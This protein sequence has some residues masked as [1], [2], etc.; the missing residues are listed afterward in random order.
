MNTEEFDN[1][2]KILEPYKLKTIPRTSSNHYHDEK[3]DV[4]HK[5]RETTAEHVFSTLRLADYFLETEPEF[6]GLDKL[7]VYELLMYHD[8]VEILT[9]DTGIAE[10]EKRK[11]KEQEEQEAIPVLYNRFPARL[12]DKL[13]EL[14]TEYRAGETLESKFAQAVDK[15]DSLVH[16]FQYPKDWGPKGFDEKLVRK[17]FQPVFE[18]STTFKDYFETT[19][20]YLET[21]GYFKK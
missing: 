9:R 14:D 2:L 16:E 20:N 5:R 18:Y 11:N 8:D 21:N 10:V 12:D 19:I 1:F 3:D 4:Y 17:L 6:A 15:M 13:V 7:K